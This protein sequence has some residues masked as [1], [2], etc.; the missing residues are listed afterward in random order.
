M[1]AAAGVAGGQIL[2]MLDPD[3]GVPPAWNGTIEIDAFG[4]TTYTRGWTPQAACR[5]GAADHLARTAAA[6]AAK[7]AAQDRAGAT[8]GA[9]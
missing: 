2:R 8:T 7:A 9:P 5:C 3:E 1:T 6:E 4:A